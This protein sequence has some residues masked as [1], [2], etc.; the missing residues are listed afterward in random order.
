[1][2]A[3]STA[4]RAALEQWGVAPGRIQVVYNQID[5]DEV[6][7]SAARTPNPSLPGLDKRPRIL[8][9]AHLMR[10]KG[11]HTAIRDAGL[12]KRQG[13]DFS[14]WLAGAQPTGARD[15]FEEHLKDLVRDTTCKSRHFLGCRDA[16]DHGSGGHR[17]LADAHEGLPRV[18]EE[19][20]L[21]RKPVTPVG[22]IAISS[23]TARR[24]PGAGRGRACCLC[25]GQRGSLRT[26]LGA[27]VNER[28]YRRVRP[29]PRQVV[30]VRDAFGGD[31]E[32]AAARWRGASG[33]GVSSE[34][35]RSPH[36]VGS[37]AASG[38][39]RKP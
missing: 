14:L 24:T 15:S 32:L 11:Q 3:V 7:A 22:G 6:L 39:L 28:P 18:V 35:W 20:M 12:W 17:A 38:I 4:T 16:R 2:L 26:R 27:D 30:R 31:G 10:Q 33:Y 25:R 34:V 13:A 9:P 36:A 8:V 37:S 23:S 21:L 1:V 5:F 29:R 19:A